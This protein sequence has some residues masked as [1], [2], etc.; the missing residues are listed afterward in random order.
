MIYSRE[1]LKFYIQEDAKSNRIKTNP[2]NYLAHLFV[3]SENYHAFQYLRCLRFC[4]YHYNNNN[5]LRYYFYKIRLRRL[6]IKHHLYI[7]LNI[8]GYGLK[9][10]HIIGKGGMHIGAKKI[11]NYCG[12]N[13]GVLMGTKDSQD[14]RPIVGDNV[15]F[16]PGSVVIGAIT[17]GN[18]AYIAP[19]AVVTKDVPENAIVGGIPA[20]ILKYKE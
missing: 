1:D 6:G 2:L 18:N 4:E 16:C 5:K 15:I 11:G 14:A 8:C 9:I 20:K 17:I 12:V 13:T 10:Y 19:N 3:G 7:G